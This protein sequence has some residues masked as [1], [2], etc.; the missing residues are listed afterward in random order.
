MG[1]GKEQPQVKWLRLILHIL[2]EVCSAGR[3]VGG[4]G[5]VRVS[6]ESSG[7]LVRGGVV[8]GV[9]EV[10]VISYLPD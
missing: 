4:L 5:W 1:L 10:P 9:V 7:V 6:R 2:S 8:G 3:E